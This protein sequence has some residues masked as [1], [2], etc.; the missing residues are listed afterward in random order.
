[1]FSGVDLPR[2]FFK[3]VIASILELYCETLYGS[4]SKCY[5]DGTHLVHMPCNI[6]DKKVVVVQIRHYHEMT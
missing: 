4:I 1:M 3:T 6:C 2:H 5:T